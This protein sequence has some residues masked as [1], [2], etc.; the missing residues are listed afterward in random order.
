MLSEQK[1]H[2]IV[3]SLPQRRRKR[4][5]RLAG[6]LWTG[7]IPIQNWFDHFPIAGVESHCEKVTAVRARLGKVW[8][9]R[10]QDLDRVLVAGFNRVMKRRFAGPVSRT[11]ICRQTNKLVENVDLAVHS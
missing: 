10:Q 1:P 5:S 11:N 7:R 2:T 9:Q 8:G 4:A 3:I 6:P